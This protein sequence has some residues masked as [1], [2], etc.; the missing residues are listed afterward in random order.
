MCL[1]T[2]APTEGL[3][4]KRKI[5]TAPPWVGIFIIFGA[6]PYAILRAAIGEQITLLVPESRE[7]RKRRQ[8]TAAATV[9]LVFVGLLAFTVGAVKNQALTEIV[10]AL[11]FVGAIGL[12][13]WN[14]QQH[15]IG[16]RMKH[17]DP[18]VTLKR[19]NAD[20][21]SQ[22]QALMTPRPAGSP[23]PPPGFATTLR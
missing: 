10:G 6:L 20:V 17:K 1:R 4:Q 15:S 14:G 23:L 21:A 5:T 18:T 19:L 3:V 9:A 11:V 12:A 13:I 2:G 22:L 16:V 8:L 7:V